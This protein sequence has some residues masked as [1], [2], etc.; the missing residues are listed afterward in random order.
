MKESNSVDH[1]WKI[2]DR[3]AED[4]TAEKYDYLYHRTFFARD[5]YHSFAETIKNKTGGGKVLELACG[6]AII[7]HILGR[8]SVVERYCIDFSSNML[9]IAKSRCSNCIQADIDSLPLSD[10]SFDLVY[11]HSALHHF[12]SLTKII[13]E[14]KRILRPGGLF[15][16]QEPNSHHIKMDFFLRHFYSMLRK[17]KTKK[18]QDVS[19]L[20]IKPSEHHAPIEMEKVVSVLEEFGFHIL[21]K[22]YKYYSSYIFSSYDSLLVHRIGRI[23][24]SYYINKNKEGYMFFIISRK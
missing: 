15:I 19:C 16:I 8:Y 7:S 3:Q 5:M 9:H 10:S 22:E 12:T 6:T 20:E 13:T 11:V 21:E 2:E 14:V 4:S 24:D 23:M 17:L 1:S 18:Y